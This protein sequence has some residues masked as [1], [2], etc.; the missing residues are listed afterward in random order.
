MNTVTA[1]ALADLVM[2]LITAGFGYAS[3]RGW[4]RHRGRDFPAFKVPIH[5]TLQIVGIVAWA[6]FVFTGAVFVAWT[7]FVILTAGQVVGDLLMFASYRA[8]HPEIVKL[9]YLSAGGDVLSFRRP[10]AGFHATFGAIAWFGMLAI[11][12]YATV[13]AA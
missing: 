1:F 12:I 8:R 13:A 5:L 9:K 11:C 6:A 3:L 7:A 10:N 2:L 4:L